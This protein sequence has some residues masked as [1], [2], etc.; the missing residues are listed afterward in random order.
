MKNGGRPLPEASAAGEPEE[1][2]GRHEQEDIVD[3][4]DAVAAARF[5]GPANNA[6]WPRET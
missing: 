3:V 4:D 5:R 6:I 2:S 1:N